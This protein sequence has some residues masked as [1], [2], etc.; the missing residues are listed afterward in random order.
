[1]VDSGLKAVA[2]HRPLTTNHRPLAT[3]HRPLAAKIGGRRT[4]VEVPYLNPTDMVKGRAFTDPNRIPNDLNTWRYMTD[5]ICLFLRN[6][7]LYTGLKRPIVVHRPDPDKWLYRLIMPNPERL[8]TQDTITFVG[9]L[10][11]RRENADL[12]LGGEF[13]N[14]LVAEIPEHPDL[15]CYNTMGQSCGNYGNLVLFASEAAKGD[16]GRSKAHAQAVSNLA[17]Q[18]YQSIR[19]Y[20]GTLPL[21]VSDSHALYLTKVKYFDYE[22]KPMWHAVRH[23]E[24]RGVNILATN[25]HE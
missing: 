24:E 17:P 15:L 25:E 3:D 23:F 8:L 21:G 5:Q 7:H 6:P 9:F 13:D 10:G 12:A 18:Y 19:L 11:K 20:N 16:W 1:V 4:V 2:E 22:Q 14:I